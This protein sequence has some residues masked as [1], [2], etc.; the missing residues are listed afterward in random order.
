M[1][2]D[3]L[4]AK[5]EELLKQRPNDELI[6]FSLGKAFYDAKRLA[7]AEKYLGTALEA[8]PEWMVVTMLLAKIALE[9]DDKEKARSL[10]EKALELAI[11]QDHEGPEEEVRTALA[12][13]NG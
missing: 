10:Y 6:L 8:K 2:T 12:R 13:L 11:S 5:Y 9:R 4:I 3:A 1:N 7:D